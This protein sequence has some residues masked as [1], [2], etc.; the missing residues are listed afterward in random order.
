MQVHEVVATPGAGTLRARCTVCGSPDVAPKWRARGWS[1]MACSAC[2]AWFVGEAQSSDEIA[3]RYSAS[4]F[5]GGG[6]EAY[7]DYFR[8]EQCH[9]KQARYY[10]RK[11]RRLKAPAGRILDVGCA[12]GFF[13]DEARRA[14]WE[15]LGC[16]LSGFAATRARERLGLDVFEGRF[17]DY[18]LDHDSID[19]ATLFSVL[20]HVEDPR[21]VE[22][23]LHEV[24]R[25]GGMV[26]L[27]TSN[28][29]AAVPR[30]LGDRWHLLSPPT[31]LHYYTRR[32]L[33]ALFPPDRWR[34][35]AFGASIK[36]ISLTH[37]LSRVI[38]RS[39]RHFVSDGEGGG[40]LW[41]LHV[42]YLG[43][44]LAIAA[45]VKS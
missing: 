8:D 21:A 15:P 13:L 10:L 35:A 12:G 26:F 18:G 9:R 30:L 41:E 38:G 40:A 34:L 11:L 7:P 39:S 4:Y 27:E 3:S 20:A 17:E 2:T 37:A 36:W 14:G 23:K 24:V 31:V 16:E 19:V 42:P 25:P 32:S 45:F 44:D 22:S 6:F 33:Q 29:D 1:I 28:H 5:E 43:R